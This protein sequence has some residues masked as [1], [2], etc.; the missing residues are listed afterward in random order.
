MVV[1]VS[2]YVKRVGKGKVG[3]SWLGVFGLSIGNS[4]DGSK[5]GALIPGHCRRGRRPLMDG[6]VMITVIPEKQPFHVI[7]SGREKMEI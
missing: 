7:V 1:A 2:R 6:V 5:L 3:T 4:P